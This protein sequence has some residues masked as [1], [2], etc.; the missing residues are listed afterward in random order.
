MILIEEDF[1]LLDESKHVFNEELSF[2]EEYHFLRSYKVAM[3]NLSFIENSIRGFYHEPYGCME[4]YKGAE[5]FYHHEEINRCWN[6]IKHEISDMERMIKT[7]VNS[8][9]WNI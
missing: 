2:V 8:K 6:L 1:R 4:Y 5:G 3:D 9:E 7:G